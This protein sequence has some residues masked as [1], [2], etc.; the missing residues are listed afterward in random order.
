MITTNN[1][2]WMISQYFL[3][4]NIILLALF[5]I[6]YFMGRKGHRKQPTVLNMYKGNSDSKIPERDA[7]SSAINQINTEIKPGKKVIT[8]GKR[9]IVLEDDEIVSVKNTKSLNI[10]FNYNGHSWDAYEVL[11][12]PAGA[13]I[14]VVTKAY[15]DAIRGADPVKIDFLEQAYKSILKQF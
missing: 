2:I 1:K 5:A 11:G 6:F 9:Q 12:V 15:Q 4:I 8:Y 10:M 13:N 7:Q 3:E 14:S